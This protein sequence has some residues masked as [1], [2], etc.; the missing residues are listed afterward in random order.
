LNA[1]RQADHHLGRLFAALRERHLDDDT[2]VV[3]TGDHGEA[4][5]DAHDVM[6]HGGGLFEENLHVPLMFWNPRLFPQGRRDGLAGGH[7]DINPT[8]AHLLGLPPPDGWQGA[9]LLS[10]DHPGRVYL[11]ADLSGY[12]FGVTDGR[13]KE[14]LRV[15]EGVERLYDLSDDPREQR[16]LSSTRRDVAASMHARVSAFVHAEERYLHGGDP[17]SVAR[18]RDALGR[19]RGRHARALVGAGAPIVC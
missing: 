1:V 4:F 18:S 8:I 17:P 9:S 11:L 10:P 14:I 6:G 12:Q 13:W 2:L 3:V 16:D 7:V 15:S 19:S 5:G